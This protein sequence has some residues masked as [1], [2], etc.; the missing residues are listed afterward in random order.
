MLIGMLV[1]TGCSQSTKEEKTTKKEQSKMEKI[2]SQAKT[3]Q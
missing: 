3:D 2:I 1:L